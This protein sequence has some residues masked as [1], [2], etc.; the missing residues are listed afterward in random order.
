MSSN[1]IGARGITVTVELE[2]STKSCSSMRV[3]YC[4]DMPAGL[5]FS[6]KVALIA[7]CCA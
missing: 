4:L 1:D 6:C 2:T 7:P 5:D 3:K